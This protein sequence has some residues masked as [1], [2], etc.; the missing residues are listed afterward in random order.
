MQQRVRMSHRGY[1]LRPPGNSPSRWHLTRGFLLCSGV[2]IQ[3]LT[4]KVNSGFGESGKL[5]FSLLSAAGVIPSPGERVC[6][7][8]KKPGAKGLRAKTYLSSIYREARLLILLSKVER[9]A[10]S[11]SLK[12]WVM[13]FSQHRSIRVICGRISRVLSVG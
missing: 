7:A 11:S 6:A 13:Q 4:K 12:S 2:T 3:H 10:F 1:F 5:S 8:R 9:H